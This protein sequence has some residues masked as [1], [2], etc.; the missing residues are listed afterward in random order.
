MSKT[1][2]RKNQTV[3]Q[4][5]RDIV[6]KAKN[7]VRK[8]KRQPYVSVVAQFDLPESTKRIILNQPK[9]ITEMLIHNKICTDLIEKNGGRVIKELGD[10]ILALFPSVPAACE[11]G[12]KAIHNFKKYGGAICT[13]VTVT[14]GSLEEVSTRCEPDVYGAAVNLCNRM[15]RWA[16]TDSVLIEETRFEEVRHWLPDDAKIKFGRPIKKDLK[17]FRKLKVRKITLDY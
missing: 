11:C 16:S 14:A 3:R 5:Y 12:L 7:K 13:K 10:A 8:L 1:K 6:S 4:N 9:T 2:Q 17:E 15:S